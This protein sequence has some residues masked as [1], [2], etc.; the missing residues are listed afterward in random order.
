M[1]NTEILETMQHLISMCKKNIKWKY[2]G[3]EREMCRP[4][5]I[6]ALCT[7]VKYESNVSVY[8]LVNTIQLQKE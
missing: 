1:E 7:V 4:M 6:T 2:Q 5:L 3:D 8:P